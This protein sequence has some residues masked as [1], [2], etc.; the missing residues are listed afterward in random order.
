[1]DLLDRFFGLWRCWDPPNAGPRGVSGGDGADD[2]A[3][4]AG[5]GR[6]GSRRDG[7][8]RLIRI[9]LIVAPYCAR[10]FAIH[11]WTGSVMYSRFLRQWGRGGKSHHPLQKVCYPPRRLAAGGGAAV[12][13]AVGGRAAAAT[14]G[15]RSHKAAAAAGNDVPAVADAGAAAAGRRAAAGNERR[16]GKRRLLEQPALPPRP[17]SPHLELRVSGAREEHCSD[18]GFSL[19]NHGP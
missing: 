13:A 9:D 19:T 6:V 2:G 14:G 12:A 7:R 17:P 16:G 15:G 10:A 5:G 18:R 11:G 1:M 4:R 3:A 8:E